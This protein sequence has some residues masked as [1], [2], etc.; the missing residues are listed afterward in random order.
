MAVQIQLRR[1]EAALWTSANP[2]LAEGE[3][4]L[5]VDTGK[6]KFGNG[7]D[8]W[9]DLPYFT[10][11]GGAV[12]SVN[13]QTGVVVLDAGD[14]GLGNVD[15]TSDADKIISDDT[16]DAL[17]L[18]ADASALSSY[19]PT[20][21]T[22]NGHALSANVT[23]TK[24]DVGL[25]NADNTADIAKPVSTDQA[26]ADAA[27]LTA[28]ESYADALVVGLLDDRGN[29]DASGNAFPAT[30]GSG[31]AG[32]ILKGDL[33]T[34]SVA[35]TLGGHPVTA[36]DVVRALVDTPGSTD[37]NWAISENNFGYVAENSANKDA[38]GGYAGL[39][40]FKLNLKNAAGAVT[41]WLVSAATS[42]RTWTF[43][44][45]DGTVAMTSDITGTNSGTN[46]GDQSSIVGITGTIAQFNTA[47]T[48]ADFATGGGTATGTN[49]GDQT[50][51]TGNA[52][53]A[54]ALQNARTIDGVSFNGTTNI[55]VIA[56]GTNAATGKTTPVDADELPLVDSAASNVLKKLTWANL[57]AALRAYILPSGGSTGQVLAKVNGTD[58]NVSWQT[59]SGGGGG[60][61]DPIVFTDGDITTTYAG[62]GFQSVDSSGT[63]FLSL[64][65]ASGLYSDD[66]A[67][68]YFALSF[69]EMYVYG[70]TGYMAYNNGSNTF[71]VRQDGPSD[72]KLAGLYG[73]LGEI[74]AL[75]NGVSSFVMSPVALIASVDAGESSTLSVAGGLTFTSGMTFGPTSITGREI[76]APSAPAANQYILF[77]QDNGAGK[78]QLMVRFATGAAQQLAIEP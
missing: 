13:G 77:A 27:V 33:W 8:A 15:N 40:A 71:V 20:T 58:Y 78:T 18:K 17:D 56:P 37:A 32:A 73:E 36:G 22:V 50:N 23:V 59:V 55:T 38:S 2:I 63:I 64:N 41:S 14:V 46:T 6:L 16:Q 72:F 34:I 54:T 42:A 1:G 61:T 25:G 26:A 53:T 49:T 9:A 74:R 43:P 45:K 57:K 76:S 5:E 30:G 12:D 44:D 68:K 70:A 10:A 69:N 7:T 3:A 4:G 35:G 29:F 65:T 51:V 52:G 24:G 39:T 28:A 67:S 60:V 66:G 11:G 47:C 62:T 48:D 31:A 75:H 19:V 21:R